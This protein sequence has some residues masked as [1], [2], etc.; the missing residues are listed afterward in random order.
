VAHLLLHW[1]GLDSASG[2]VYLFYSGSGSF[3]L[4]G[5][6][7]AVLW[8]HLNC[9]EPRCRRPARHHMNGYCR[10]HAKERSDV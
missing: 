2:L 9:H 8:H 7:V 4:K 5:S 10:K 3:I 1:L 6:I